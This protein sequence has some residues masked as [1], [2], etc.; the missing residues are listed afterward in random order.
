MDKKTTDTTSNRLYYYCKLAT[1]I[2][3]ILPKKQLLLN[4]VGR[5]NDPRENKDFLFAKTY[6]FAGNILLMDKPDHEITNELRKDCKMLCFS[7]D[8]GIFFGYEYSRMWALYGDNHK[9]VC[10]CLNKEKFII[11]NQSRISPELFK[12]IF[13]TEFDISKPIEHKN[14]EIDKIRELGLRNFIRK[15]FRPQNIDH[16][17]FTKNKE[18]ESEH[19]YRLIYF[20]DKN[21]NEY[22]SIQ[23]CIEEIFLGIDFDTNYLASIKD[24]TLG[25]NISQLD[26]IDSVRLVPH[27]INK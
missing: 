6:Q 5:T 20:S 22:C 14:I 17:F 18:W 11:E 1:A 7:T 9:G 25:I 26:Y 16:L 13:Y 10:I 4:P 12:N 2:E 8:H 23:N 3:Y 19:E 24:K 15:E 21:E 27:K